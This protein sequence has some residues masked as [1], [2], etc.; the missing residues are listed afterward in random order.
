MKKLVLAVLMCLFATTAL[1]A[2][3]VTFTWDANSEQDLSGYRL[4]QTTISG[5]YV[6]GADNAVAII[7]AGTETVTIEGLPDGQF[8]WV[9]TAYD[10]DMNESGLSNEVTA[11]MDSTPPGAPTILEITAIVKAP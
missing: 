11:T 10:N 7:P 1:A 6:M 8:W 3:A 4:Y 9:V 5:E 2:N